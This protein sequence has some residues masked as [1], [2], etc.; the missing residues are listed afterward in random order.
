MLR[1]GVS[2]RREKLQPKRRTCHGDQ[3]E[4]RGGPHLAR[5]RGGRT[6]WWSADNKKKNHDQG[7]TPPHPPPH[8]CSSFDAPLFFMRIDKPSCCL[9]GQQQPQPA[10]PTMR[11]P[12]ASSSVL[13]SLGMMVLALTLDSAAAFAAP[14]VPSPLSPAAA[15]PAIGSFAATSRHRPGLPRSSSRRR[16]IPASP[17]APSTPPP[18]SKRPAGAGRSKGAAGNVKF[19]GGRVSRPVQE[20]VV[21]GSK[22]EEEEEEDARKSARWGVKPPSPPKLPQLPDVS[23]FKNPLDGVGSSLRKV[24]RMRIRESMCTCGAISM[25]TSFSQGLV[26]AGAHAPR[27]PGHSPQLLLPLLSLRVSPTLKVG[28]PSVCGCT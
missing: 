6:R 25:F 27:D 5:G 14:P 18:P 26:L 12:G 22:G 2:I 16:G 7:A 1:F 24:Y 19:K 15:G 9:Q 4:Q 21:A 28:P 8:L 20:G 13:A 3:R 17:A 11:A 23:S 10:P